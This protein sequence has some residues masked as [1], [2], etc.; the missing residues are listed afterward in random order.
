[1]NRII[2]VCMAIAAACF[3]L[4]LS[5]SLFTGCVDSEMSW[6]LAD[7][8]TQAV[9]DGN[10]D[11]HLETIVSETT[12]CEQAPNPE[13]SPT[14]LVMLSPSPIPAPETPKKTLAVDYAFHCTEHGNALP[15]PPNLP[16]DNSNSSNQV[17]WCGDFGGDTYNLN[18][19][20]NSNWVSAGTAGQDAPYASFYLL[21]DVSGLDLS[22]V[23]SMTL[24]FK[25][26]I[27]GNRVGYSSFGGITNSGFAVHVYDSENS[28]WSE[29]FIDELTTQVNGKVSMSAP[30][31][32]MNAARTELGKS[33]LRFAVI[34]HQSYSSATSVVEMLGASLEL[35]NTPT[36]LPETPVNANSTV[37]RMIDKKGNPYRNLKFTQGISGEYSG[38]ITTDAWGRL[39]YNSITPTTLSFTSSATTATSET[40]FLSH[41]NDV[42]SNEGYS[43]NITNQLKEY[44][45]VI[46]KILYED[47]PGSNASSTT[48]HDGPIHNGDGST[49]YGSSLSETTQYVAQAILP[50]GELTVCQIGFGVGINNSSGSPTPPT[51]PKIQVYT[52]VSGHPGALIKEVAPQFN[53]S[54]NYYGAVSTSRSTFG[55][56]AR[57]CENGE[58]GIIF[59]KDTIYWIV[60]YFATPPTQS[61][62]GTSHSLPT[63]QIHPLKS[64]DG[65][66]WTTAN[67]N[68]GNQEAYYGH[69]IGLFL[70]E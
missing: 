32:P 34:S 12:V 19:P 58:N 45:L 30:I 70:V 9:S 48:W 5:S 60:A 57:F 24:N 35:S 63:S 52:N 39:I 31:A 20:N 65:V 1:M 22:Q 50:P 17:A 21:F 29:P 23:S 7:K 14:A 46:P 27:G 54:A 47:A 59:D 42:G 26:L 66:T 62:V 28:S 36:L 38:P 55:T 37:I 41:P 40:T 44:S 33:Y 4:A 15:N 25:N 10:A 11:T 49:T 2:P 53:P 43:V 8:D 61:G 67:L 56:L 69:S 3:L 18:D 16:T 51:P 13:A 6:E 68:A 64:S